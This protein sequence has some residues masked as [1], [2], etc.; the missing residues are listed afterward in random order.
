MLHALV[1]ERPD[2][3]FGATHFFAHGRLPCLCI[4]T[5]NKKGP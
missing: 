3:H 4:F 2:H 1:G 5:R